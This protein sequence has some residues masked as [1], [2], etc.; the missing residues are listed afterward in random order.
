MAINCHESHLFISAMP[1]GLRRRQDN[2]LGPAK[3]F[4]PEMVVEGIAKVIV[5]VV[6]EVAVEVSALAEVV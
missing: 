2:T 1:M 4:I 5:E 6:E 3:E